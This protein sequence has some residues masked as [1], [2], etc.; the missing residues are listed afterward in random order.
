MTATQG[1]PRWLLIYGLILPLAVFLGYLVAI[2][3]TF[4]SVVFVS[5]VILVLAFP[6]FLRWH[7]AWVIFGW[8]A[9]LIFYF[10]PGQPN[11]GIVLAA[12]SLMLSVLQRTMR[13]KETFIRVPSVAN[14]VIFIGLVAA[15]TAGLTGGIGGRAL[16]TEGWG[17][18]RYL[19]VFGAVIGYFA[20]V[21][22]AVPKEKA[23]RYASM[24]TLSGITSAL[25]DMIYLAGPKFYFLFALFPSNVAMVQVTTQTGLERLSGIAFGAVSA[26]S[27][28][29]LRYGIRGTFDLRRPWRIFFFL[30][31]I[32]LSLL[33]GYRS[34]LI[35]PVILLPVQFYFEGLFKGRWL[36][37]V[38]LASS[39]MACGV[40]AF[41]DK[42][43]LS[44][45]RSLSFLPI[46]I[47]PTARTDAQGTVEWRLQIWRVVVPEIPRYLLLGKGFTY[48]GTDYYLTEEAIRR[49]IY[50]QDVYE[51]ALIAGDYHQGV[52]TILMPFGI[53]GMI[54]FVWSCWASLRVLYL[55]HRH[56][57]ERLKLV[58]TFLISNFVARL[59]FYVFFY[60]Q[61]EQDFPIFVG[62]IAASIS[63]NG[64][65][66]TD[67]TPLKDE[68]VS[69]LPEP[70]L[71]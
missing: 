12:G 51:G 31:F 36:I 28:M 18:K 64:G 50:V 27:F 56:G 70:A 69:A 68:D 5:A 47:D 16:G 62:I 23:V 33:G 41:S 8:N 58:N 30:L 22:K 60:G 42:L 4:V 11:L 53:W 14:S 20:I 29:L 66:C 1:L 9:A 39:L 48:S 61:F 44:V 45:Q 25:C 7:H 40:A 49:G 54:G 2:P 10:A 17:A 13:N 46:R 67:K 52:L 37:P 71:T 34:L 65:V 35:I 3:T 63:L 57:E 59:I 24:F 38:A 15:V 19:G 21:A 6:L 32:A 43:P 55:N 26:W